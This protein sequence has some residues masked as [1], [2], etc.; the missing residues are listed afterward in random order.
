MVT[1]TTNKFKEELT[2]DCTHI[3]MVD[4]HSSLDTRRYKRKRTFAKDIIYTQ[5]LYLHHE[6]IRNPKSKV[7]RRIKSKM[8]LTS[9]LINDNIERLDEFSTQDMMAL[10][11]QMHLRTN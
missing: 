3:C 9:Q 4:Q 2:E 10:K 6:E 8:Q 1:T 7:L 11:R 5:K